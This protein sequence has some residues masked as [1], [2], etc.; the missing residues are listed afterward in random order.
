MNST[1]K[2]VI[3]FMKTIEDDHN[4]WIDTPSPGFQTISRTRDAINIKLDKKLNEHIIE[5]IKEFLSSKNI[6]KVYV[7]PVGNQRKLLLEKYNFSYYDKHNNILSL[8]W[9]I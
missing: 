3:L 1:P 4:C 8:E 9:N 6:N 5:S 2:A 7:S